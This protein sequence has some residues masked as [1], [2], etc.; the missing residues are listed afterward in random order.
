MTFTKCHADKIAK[1]DLHNNKKTLQM[2]CRN[3]IL[4]KKQLEKL[5]NG[6]CDE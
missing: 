4:L 5:N 2:K 3:F 1:N 6:E